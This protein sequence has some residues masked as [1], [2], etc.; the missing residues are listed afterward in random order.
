MSKVV[1]SYHPKDD[2]CYQNPF[3]EK[4]LMIT[5][6]DFGAIFD[7]LYQQIFDASAPF[8]NISLKLQEK[9]KP[10]ILS[11]DFLSSDKDSDANQNQQLIR[12]VNVFVQLIEELMKQGVDDYHCIVPSFSA[13]QACIKTGWKPKNVSKVSSISKVLVFLISAG[14]VGSDQCCS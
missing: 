5:N 13:L 8:P 3:N 11:Q 12:Q 2:I 6:N 7:R 4:D 9:L 1:A 14:F 10:S